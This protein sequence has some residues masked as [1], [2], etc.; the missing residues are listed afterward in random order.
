M[1]E[2]VTLLAGTVEGFELGACFTAS[3]HHPLLTEEH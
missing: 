2:Q 1:E 3:H